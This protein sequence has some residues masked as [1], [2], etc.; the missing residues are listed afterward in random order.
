LHSARISCGTNSLITAPP[1]MPPR[2][3]TSGTL[4]LSTN[5]SCF[6]ASWRLIFE[7]ILRALLIGEVTHSFTRFGGRTG[8]VTQVPW[9]FH[10]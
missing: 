3:N 1:D 4:R 7:V 9:F 10:K 5:A 8:A 2:A 6:W